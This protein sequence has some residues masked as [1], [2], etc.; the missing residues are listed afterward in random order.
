MT[1]G[2]SFCASAETSAQ[3][4]NRPSP[5][6]TGMTLIE[7]LIVL[8][9]IAVAAGAVTFGIGAASR[10]PNV[11]T[12]AR[13]LAGRI[14]AA[15]DDAM[16]GDR[17]VALTIR[18]DGYAFSTLEG[19]AWKE[20]TDDALAFHRVPGGM[21]I[22]LDTAPPIVLNGSTMGKP[23]TAIVTS[24]DQRWRIVYDGLIAVALPDNA[25]PAT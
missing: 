24:G 3:P 12:E 7:M 23:V 21:A 19:A 10:T 20:R 6:E 25:A 4:G 1:G 8:A 15:S 11:E 22:E 18:D 13:R 17:I 5:G 14:Q 9:I 2:T 16:L